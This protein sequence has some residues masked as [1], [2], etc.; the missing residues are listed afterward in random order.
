MILHSCQIHAVLP[1]VRGLHRM[2]SLHGKIWFYAR[3]V[4]FSKKILHEAYIGGFEKKC[5]RP[6]WNLFADYIFSS[7]GC[8]VFSPIFL[9]NFLR[10]CPNHEKI[11]QTCT[12]GWY[13]EVWLSRHGLTFHGVGWWERAR[14]VRTEQQ[15]VH[16]SR[17]GAKTMI[18]S[19]KMRKPKKA[20]KNKKTKNRPMAQ[21]LHLAHRVSVFLFFC[22]SSYVIFKYFCICFLWLFGYVAIWFSE[23]CFS[24]CLKQCWHSAKSALQC[25]PVLK[26]NDSS[27]ISD[28]LPVSRCIVELYELLWR[29]GHRKKNRQEL[30]RGLTGL[31]RLIWEISGTQMSLS[32][33]LHPG[34]PWRMLSGAVFES[35]QTVQIRSAPWAGPKSAHPKDLKGPVPL[36]M[37]SVLKPKTRKKLTM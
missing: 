3:N 36:P 15:N 8:V 11:K 20:Q 6:C 34:F 1:Y 37:F 26:K 27:M 35:F 21:G 9:S 30:W 4:I 2:I 28:D 33:S 22:L 23:N 17:L 18:H 10:G 32:A 19:C 31:D 14:W 12:F 25:S 7:R 16:R 13:P 29:W 24:L 5:Q